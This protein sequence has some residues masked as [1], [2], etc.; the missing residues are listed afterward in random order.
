MKSRPYYTVDG[1]EYWKTKDGHFHREDGPAV[2]YSD[3]AQYYFVNN[4][5]HRLDG[6]AIIKS[7]NTEQYFIDNKEYEKREYYKVLVKKGL[8]TFQEALPDLI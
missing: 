1:S 5:L 6:P 2:T 3:G 8:M 4:K 7:N